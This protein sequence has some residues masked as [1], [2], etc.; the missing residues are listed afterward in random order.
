MSEPR[1]DA[2]AVFALELACRQLREAFPAGECYLVGAI[3]ERATVRLVLS[4]E[5]F[6]ETF[7]DA[8]PAWEHDARWLLL[9]VVLSMW[10]SH[11]VR[12][13]VD[14]RFVPRRSV[15][16]RATTW[17]LIGLREPSLTE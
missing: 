7:P 16:V 12:L 5:V 6:S 15:D 3:R 8:V 17:R 2:Q 1:D 4:D 11:F 13:P 10:L 9:T 14:L